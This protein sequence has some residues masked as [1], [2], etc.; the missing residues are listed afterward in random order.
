MT[1]RL[2]QHSTK[3]QVR[4]AVWNSK[5]WWHWRSTHL[6]L[7]LSIP[8]RF[9][10]IFLIYS[11]SSCLVKLRL[12]S[13]S[14]F[15][16]E[17]LKI[18]FAVDLSFAFFQFLESRTSLVICGCD[19]SK[20]SVMNILP[21]GS[22]FLYATTMPFPLSKQDLSS[23]ILPFKA[24]AHSALSGGCV[25]SGTIKSVASKRFVVLDKLSSLIFLS[26]LRV[27]FKVRFRIWY[28][29]ELQWL[30]QV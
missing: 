12:P 11:K 3:N 18:T 20:F 13:S 23:A 2:Q 30:T 7:P 17:V 14:L 6:L 21:F 26:L 8:E 25:A 19:A 29:Q 4:N 10:S 22:L 15:S 5:W 9:I 16:S 28:R 1:F 27:L 24:A